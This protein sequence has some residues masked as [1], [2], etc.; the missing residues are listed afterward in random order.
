MNMI[1]FVHEGLGNSSYLV[2]VGSDEALL[3][4]PNRGVNQYL[5]AAEERGWKI[6]SVL[7]THVHADFV[8]GVRDV[9]E[10][11]GAQIYAPEEGELVFPHRPIKAG[12]RFGLGGVEIEAIASPGHSPEHTSYVVRAGQESPALFSGGSMIV[13]GAARTDLISPEMTDDLTHAQ[14]RTLKTAFSS[15]PD[16]TLLY[17]TH[18][19]GS[20]CSAVPGTARTSTLGQ[21]REQN[22]VLS[23]KDEDEFVRWFPTTFP[24]IPAYF[25]RMRPI[26]Q[27]GPRL[28]GEIVAPPALRPDEF[29]AAMQKALV[30]DVRSTAAYAAGHIP[31]SLSNEFRDSYATWLGWLAPENKPLLF[32]RDEEPLEQIVAESLLVGYEGFVGWLDGGIEAWGQ[33]GKPLAKSPLINASEARAALLD[34]AIALDVREPGEFAAGHV[35]EAISIPLG[36]LSART[37]ELPKDRPI[38]AYCGHGER[39]ASGVSILER[40]GFEKL[41]NMDGGFGAWEKA[42][43]V[44]E[45]AQ[46]I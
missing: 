30:V 6:A 14:F 12:E 19:S 16:E 29:E 27:Q 8:S 23:I 1:P 35:A 20:F 25:P 24:A 5:R 15:L 2:Q 41:L 11:S 31:G 7:E 26:N 13:G 39:S 42:G 3:V 45:Q 46:T 40:A 17:P 38:V 37:D 34:G 4:D 18:G 28:R 33:A 32:V 22:A 43:H 9:A 44:Q 21:E 36:Q 10:A